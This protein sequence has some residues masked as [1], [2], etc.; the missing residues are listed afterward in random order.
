MAAGAMMAKADV[1]MN[2]QR[3][4]QLR[5]FKE[6]HWYVRF[7]PVSVALQHRETLSLL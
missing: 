1:M 3:S 5:P 2:F 6:Q 7:T 4:R